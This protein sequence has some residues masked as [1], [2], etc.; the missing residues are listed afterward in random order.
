MKPKPGD[1][2]ICIKPALFFPGIQTGERYMIRGYMDEDF[3]W[4]GRNVFPID[5]FELDVKYTR[6]QKLKILQECQKLKG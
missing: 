1:Y 6:L 3:I 2:V 5:C 4:I